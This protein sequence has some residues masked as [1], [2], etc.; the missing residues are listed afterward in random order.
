MDR[1]VTGAIEIAK[2]LGWTVRKTR[3][4]LEK[5]QLAASKMGKLWASTPRRLL[6]Q[7]GG[8]DVGDAANDR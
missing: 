6:A 7:F 8:N 4:R 2:V 5:G 3:D 1:P